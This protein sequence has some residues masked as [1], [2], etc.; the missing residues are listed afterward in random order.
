MKSNN[1]LGQRMVLAIGLGVGLGV[2]IG[3]VIGLSINN[4]LL[5]M[6]TGL[7][8]GVV[9]VLII[10]KGIRHRYKQKKNEKFDKEG[11]LKKGS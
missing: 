4:L 2:G 6:A 3:T 9:L 1:H 11:Y 5:G 10:G 8:L 7:V